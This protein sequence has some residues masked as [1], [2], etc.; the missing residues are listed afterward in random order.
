[1]TSNALITRPHAE[2]ITVTGEVQRV[3]LAASY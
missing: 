2:D 1:M 3:V